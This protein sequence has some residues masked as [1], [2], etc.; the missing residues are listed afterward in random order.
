M[1]GNEN[2]EKGPQAEKD[3]VSSG[4]EKKEAEFSEGALQCLGEIKSLR[5]NLDFLEE[6]VLKQ[7]KLNR[8]GD[9]EDSQEMTPEEASKFLA[10]LR[11]ASDAISAALDSSSWS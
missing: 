1:T 7:K 11:N 2:V 5:Q 9:W 8:V 10:N 6:E 3:V 4:V